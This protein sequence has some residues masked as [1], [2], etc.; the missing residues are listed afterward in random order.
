MRLS[1]SV[2]QKL[3]EFAKKISGSHTKTEAIHRGLQA[4]VEQH[5]LEQT[6]RHAGKIRLL[7]SKEE[8]IRQREIGK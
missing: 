5:R 4:L 1:V 8:L 6:I 2:D 7:L 3:L